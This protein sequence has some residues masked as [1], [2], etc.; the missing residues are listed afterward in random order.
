[1][2]FGVEAATK[3]AI[4]TRAN[5][6]FDTRLFVSLNE[7]DRLINETPERVDEIE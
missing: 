6:G 7:V 2:R 1:M 3:F 5:E 4:R